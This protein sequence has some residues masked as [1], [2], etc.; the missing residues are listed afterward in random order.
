MKVCLNCEFR[1]SEDGWCCPN[2]HYKPSEEFGYPAFAPDLLQGD[3]SD[4]DYEFEEL[5]TA[6]ANHFWFRVRNRILIWALG[7]YFPKAQNFLEIGCGT[8]FVIHGIGQV[9][10]ELALSASEIQISGLGFVKQR[11]PD[12]PIYQMNAL[13]IPFDSEFDVIGAFDV[14]EHIDMDEA[15]LS[16]MK[17]VV[18]PGGGIMITVPQHPRLWSHMDEFSHHKRRYT[19]SDLTAKLERAGFKPLRITSFMASLVP[20]LSMARYSTRADKVDFD[21]TAELKVNPLVNSLFEGILSVE[22]EL[23]KSGISF[24]FGGSL[25][26]IA[27]S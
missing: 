9:Y 23:I 19:K 24:P 22:L 1:F 27:K 6:E 7:A 17:R 15:V 16:E 13:Q 8:G 21:P 14:I 10:P 18:K 2:C 20:A 11:L 25:L 12:I 4:A 5:F 26:A 3:G